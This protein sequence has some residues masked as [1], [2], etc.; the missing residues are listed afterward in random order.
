VADVSGWDSG[1]W[2][3]ASWGFSVYDRYISQV[4]WGTGEWNGNFGWGFGPGDASAADQVSSALV[5]SRSIEESATQSESVVGIVT[6]GSLIT[7]SADVADQT[8]STLEI[9]GFVQEARDRFR[10]I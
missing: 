8:S 4:G 10:P 2:G 9:G 1:G 3:E 6:N 7:E 5:V